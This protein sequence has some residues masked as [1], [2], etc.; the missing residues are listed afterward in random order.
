MLILD[1]IRYK[2]QILIIKFNI[3]NDIFNFSSII[4]RYL[5][6]LYLNTKYL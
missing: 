6:D 2:Y 4:I 1:N 3:K 5:Q